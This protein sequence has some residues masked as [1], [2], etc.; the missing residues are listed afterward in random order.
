MDELHQQTVNLLSFQTVPRMTFDAQ[1]AYNLLCGL[2]ENA[3]ANLSTIEARIRRHYSALAG[4]R[5]PAL[6][7]QVTH[8]AGLSRAQF[9]DR[10]GSGAAGG[11]CD[12]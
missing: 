5:L 4:R 1:V 10:R 3:K 11:D 6:A 9:F 8:R 12:A 2:G 7:L